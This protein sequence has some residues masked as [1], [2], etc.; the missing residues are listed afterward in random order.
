MN[1]YWGCRRCL[2]K[3][4][5][6][7]VVPNGFLHHSQLGGQVDVCLRRHGQSAVE[8]PET[9]LRKLEVKEVTPRSSR[10]T[11]PLETALQV[12]NRRH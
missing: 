8:M 3:F 11:E 5:G 12:A 7:R 9:D 4:E 2:H 6:Q 1:Y 10:V